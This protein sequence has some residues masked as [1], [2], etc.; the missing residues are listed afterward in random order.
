MFAYIN[1]GIHGLHAFLK[2][3]LPDDKLNEAI[4]TVSTSSELEG[5]I[6]IV[7][8]SIYLHQFASA[9]K[10][11]MDEF[12]TSD[13][14]VTTHI[15]AIIGKALSLIRKKIKPIFVIDGKP[16][17]DKG[18]LLEKRNDSRKKA[19]KRMKEIKKETD[20]L[21]EQIKKIPLSG[22]DVEEHNRIF[23]EIL[24]LQ[25][26]QT[27]MSKRTVH[28]SQEQT[29]DIVKILGML[30][31]PCVIARGEA[32]PQC[33]ELV[34]SGIG[35]YVASEDMDML[36][37]GT[38]VLMRSL[39]A[40]DEAL[41]F[42]LEPILEGLDITIEQFVD[43][44]ILL[45]CDYSPTITGLGPKKVLPLIKQYGSIEGI[46]H[47]YP[48]FSKKFTIKPDFNYLNA[49]E[50]F[51]HPDVD[52]YDSSDFRWKKPKKSKLVSFLESYE[53]ASNRINTIS[54]TITGGFYSVMCGEQTVEQFVTSESKGKIAKKH[55]MKFNDPDFDV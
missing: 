42:T 31:I 43:V 7:D 23:E 50:K 17:E 47:N 53:F 20:I 48:D 29:S 35:D 10:G 32:D 11:S 54:D 36:T 37:F 34:K 55:S 12:K 41:S 19:K 28:V 24:E 3:N 45:G 4:R 30:G 40:K 51:L 9:I 14:R 27:K 39:T 6:A 18:I 2:A 25:E 38:P 16:P 13:G 8:T 26:E 21:S 46:V 5:T 52:E 44:C 1:M 22:F 15:Q 33:V 49:R